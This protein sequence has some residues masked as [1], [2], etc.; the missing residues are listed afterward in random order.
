KR[1][2]KQFMQGVG[3]SE[4]VTYSLT[5]KSFVSRLISP[6][7]QAKQPETAHIAMP[8]TED[9]YYLR[10]SLLPEMLKSL[11]YNFA[12][13]QTDLAF[14][15]LETIF[16][17]DEKTLTKQP[18]IKGRLAGTLSRHWLDHEWQQE[19]KIVDFYVM[20]GVIEVLFEFLELEV[21]YKRLNHPDLHPGR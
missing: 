10:L 19:K 4:T 13:K 17:T 15:K 11:A 5:N 14:I 7:I 8:M 21:E 9:H 2:I 20:K 1:E 12:R 3:L 16:I 6:E 18:E